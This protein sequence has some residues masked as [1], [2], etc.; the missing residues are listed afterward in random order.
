MAR[1][2][3]AEVSSSRDANRAVVCEI[4]QIIDVGKCQV[5]PR[6]QSQ[7][8]VAIHEQCLGLNRGRMVDDDVVLQDQ[9]RRID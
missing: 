5:R 9:R 6:G 4:E 7:C 3:R 1:I 8:H 2:E